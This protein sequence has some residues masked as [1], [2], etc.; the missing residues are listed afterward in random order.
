MDISPITVSLHFQGVATVDPAEA[1]N[2]RVVAALRG[3]EPRRS[4][5]DRISGLLGARTGARPAVECA[6]CP[7]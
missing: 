4:I 7:A 2:R 1:R 6:A 5:A 3:V